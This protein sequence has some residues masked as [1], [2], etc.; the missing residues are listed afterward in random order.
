M[1]M[2][3]TETVKDAIAQ[4]ID[5]LSEKELKDHK[6]LRTSMADILKW[7]QAR[8]VGFIAPKPRYISEEF[9]PP[10]LIEYIN[11]EYCQGV[12]DILIPYNWD[13]DS[14]KWKATGENRN[15]WHICKVTLSKGV[16]MKT[17]QNA[18]VL[19]SPNTWERGKD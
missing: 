16:P 3:L 5:N 1:T 11:S 7:M 14:E 19:G 17:L 12:S 9:L 8:K 15:F 4:A 10:E 13:V 18:S 6:K 2:N